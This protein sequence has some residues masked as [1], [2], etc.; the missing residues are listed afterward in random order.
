VWAN[1]RFA[2]VT[3]TSGELSIVCPEEDVPADIQSDRGWSLLKVEGPLS[4]DETG[5]LSSLLSP[6]KDACIPVFTISTFDTDYILL[7]SA[8][9]PEAK[10]ALSSLGHTITDGTG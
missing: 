2:S 6:L 10:Q 1:G 8:T 9:L 7:K 4:L 3:R 5:I